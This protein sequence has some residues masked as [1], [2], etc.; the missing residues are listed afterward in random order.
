MGGARFKTWRFENLSAATALRCMC[1]VVAGG[2]FSCACVQHLW[3]CVFGIAEVP[4]TEREGVSLVYSP[5]IASDALHKRLL[6]LHR[7]N[8]SRKACSYVC[9]ARY[10]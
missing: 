8:S 9:V 3:L 2:I 4:A 10:T 6:N 5:F 1:L 7:S